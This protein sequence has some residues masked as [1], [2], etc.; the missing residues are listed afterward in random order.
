[1]MEQEKFARE[2]E[3][4]FARDI[5]GKTVVSKSGKKFGDVGDVIFEVKSGELIHVVVK[6][7]TAYAERLELEKNKEG[8]MLIPYSAVIA[9]GDYLVVSEEDIV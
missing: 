6:N 7:P 2:E 5:V 8:Q 4:R 1:M 3:R 9:S